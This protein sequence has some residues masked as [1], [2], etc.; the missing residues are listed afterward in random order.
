M[1]PTS[2]NRRHRCRGRQHGRPALDALLRGENR[3]L[4]H[5]ARDEDGMVMWA[6]V[7][8]MLLFVVLASLLA[9]LGVV[10]HAKMETQNSADAV[11]QTGTVWMARG[12]NA[13]SATNHLVGELSALYIL[14]HSFGG[15][16]LDEGDTKPVE[17]YLSAGL[18]GTYIFATIFGQNPPPN[19]D[20]YDTVSQDPNGEATVYDAKRQ[21]KIIISKAYALHG[22]GGIIALIPPV[23]GVGIAMQQAAYAVEWKVYQEYELLNQVEDICKSELV[24]TTK[25]KLIPGLIQGLWYYQQTL[26]AAIPVTASTAVQEIAARNR[27]E[28][29]FT[30]RRQPLDLVEMPLVKDPSEHAQR[31]QLLRS[32]YP[33]VDYWR[34]PV[35]YM[36]FLGATLSGANCYYHKWTN[37]YSQSISLAMHSDQDDAQ[38]SK[39]D[40]PDIHGLKLYVI[41]D[42]DV[43]EVDKGQEPWTKREGSQRA[44]DLFCYMG[45]A[46][47]GAPLVVAPVLFRQSNPDGIICFAQAMIYSANPQTD[48]GGQNGQQPVAGWDTL[49]WTSEVPEWNDDLPGCRIVE[50]PV[51]G[52][53]AIPTGLPPRPAT[54]RIHCNW[55]AKLVPVTPYKLRQTVGWSVPGLGGENDMRDDIARRLNLLGGSTR[56][57]T[58]H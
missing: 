55:Q 15:V 3:G 47:N 56:A 54:P 1:T 21:L 18:L 13:V 27:A 6:T 9:N 57:L 36:F 38:G 8:V 30:G 52:Q 46:R 40:A 29:L 2:P 12:V 28:G 41:R 44:D 50:L 48:T 4:R 33:W 42:L 5:L 34:S 20:H 35:E 53:L 32:T 51:L 17:G 49:G 43:P 7:V 26:Q 58:T 22:V 19:S 37:T 45:F 31:F 24:Q 39:Q 16:V 10:V 14:H 11:A 25:H 23:S